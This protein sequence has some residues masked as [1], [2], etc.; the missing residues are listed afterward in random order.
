MVFVCRFRSS[1]KLFSKVIVVS[2]KEHSPS[3]N[4]ARLVINT[5]MNKLSNA[6]HKVPSDLAS[7]D[8][9]DPNVQALRELLQME[10]KKLSVLKTIHGL[11][12]AKPAS[13]S[14]SIQGSALNKA[15]GRTSGSGSG[16]NSPNLRGGAQSKHSIVVVPGNQGTR[17][18]SATTGTN[19]TSNTG[20][21]SRLQQL[22]DNI[23]V[24]QALTTCSERLHSSGN[25]KPS[26]AA[27]NKLVA[28][29]APPPVPGLTSLSSSNSQKHN[30]VSL[31]SDKL[32][33]LTSAN[34]IP[35]LKPKT[36]TS[37]HTT[38]RSSSHEIITISDSPMGKNPP[39]LLS[40]TARGA[41]LPTT[42][43]TRQLPVAVASNGSIQV[44][45]ISSS[46]I[47]QSMANS[48]SA[49]KKNHMQVTMLT[50]SSRRYRDFVLK[51]SHAKKNFQKQ[52]ERKMMVLPYP[53]AFRQVWPLIP[54]HDSGF[55]RNYGLEAVMHHFDPNAKA[56]QEKHTTRLRPTC[57]Q[58]M[59]DFAS[60]WQIRKSQSKQLLLCEAC[61]FLNLKILQHNKLSNQLKE[62]MESVKA[63]QKKFAGE[64][65][66]AKRQIL[67]VEKNTTTT[68]AESSPPPLLTNK[69]VHRVG[70]TVGQ[71]SQ[72][73]LN[74]VSRYQLVGPDGGK[75][76]N[77]SKLQLQVKN[78]RVVGSQQNTVVIPSILGQKPQ[79]L[80]A[81]GHGAS[82]A[83][84]LGVKRKAPSNAL[85]PP[86][87]VYKPAIGQKQATPLGPAPAPAV[88]TT[89]TSNTPNTGKVVYKPGSVL[90]LTLNRL[91]KQLIKRKLDEHRQECQQEDE[92][93][94]TS[95]NTSAGG[96]QRASKSRRKG[97]PKHNR[98]LS[99]SSVNSE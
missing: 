12:G 52:M 14:S 34:N 49:G 48:I 29:T 61:D 2:D 65:E 89:T 26:A 4:G 77:N 98:L 94:P 60:A 10:E 23:A 57:N 69:L 7:A 59:C 32:F 90:D 3:P 54:V 71:V 20:I 96:G 33:Q 62:L 17:S 24:D 75:N 47:K 21:S 64:C 51:Q 70:D 78:E 39:P 67:D 55:V 93:C 88:M 95:P 43:T 83:A 63:E 11:Q 15:S 37:S 31:S 13:K 91:S 38:N 1:K 56:L 16:R 28:V 84:G 27:T 68:A 81:G 99:A 92:E 19:A 66:E 58:C 46:I 8:A 50:E 9:N 73:V 25:S 44:P 86:R 40:S 36:I 53:K 45:T 72:M 41:F 87:K 5:N 30:V 42:T 35:Q 74:Q 22:V 97:T 85:P 18:S 6:H 79:P 76:N 82:K 80:Q